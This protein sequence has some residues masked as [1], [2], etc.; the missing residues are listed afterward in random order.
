MADQTPIPPSPS[1]ADYAGGA[2]A[3]APLDG[4]RDP[5]ALFAEWLEQAGRSEPNDPNAMTLATVD[6]T[7]TPDA[8]I[9]LLKA[10]DERGFS[11]FTNLT[12]AKAQELAANPRAALVFHWKSLQRQVRARGAIERVSDAEADAYFASRAR[13][14]RL[15]AWA[16]DQS[17]TLADPAILEA[18]LAEMEQR[19]AGVEPPRPPFWSGYRLIPEDIEFWQAG[20]FRL[21]ERMLF[22]R[23][24]SGPW[25]ARRLFP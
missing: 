12:S 15:G 20:A 25:N 5:L 18:R 23:K 9:L 24:G 10:L 22:E 7:G 6:A 13:I 19:F 1:H 21:H 3:G 14:S 4:R 16:S 8:R 17:K 2:G 11:F